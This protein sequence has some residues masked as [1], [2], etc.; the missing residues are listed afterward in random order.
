MVQV[1]MFVPLGI[2]S[3]DSIGFLTCPTLS[4]ASK[5]GYSPS[6]QRHAASGVVHFGE[7]VKS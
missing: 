1:R 4:S 6:F 2:T 5:L 7:K 3:Y